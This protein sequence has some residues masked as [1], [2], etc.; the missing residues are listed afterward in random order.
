VVEQSAIRK[1][2]LNPSFPAIREVITLDRDQILYAQDHFPDCRG[3]IP[4]NPAQAKQPGAIMKAGPVP[5]LSTSGSEPRLYFPA[6][7]LRARKTIPRTRNG[8]PTPIKELCLD[9]PSDM[10][11]I[12]IARNAIPT[13]FFDLI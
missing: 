4:E 3:V 5:T 10:N 1:F 9:I 12:P 8:T 7:F 2:D 11:A 6:V 13:G